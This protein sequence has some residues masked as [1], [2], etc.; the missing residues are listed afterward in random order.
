V[1][2]E[3]LHHRLADLA[4]KLVHPVEIFVVPESHATKSAAV[5]HLQKLPRTPEPTDIVVVGD[6]AF[7]YSHGVLGDPAPHKAITSRG[8]DPTLVELSAERQDF[9]VW[10]SEHPFAIADVQPKSAYP[11][12]TRRYGGPNNPFY[13]ELPFGDDDD[14]LS[15]IVVSGPVRPSASGGLF[16]VSLRIN[17]RLIDPHIAT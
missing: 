14:D 6:K 13:R 16:K 12:T 8:S 4:V 9:V 17:G 15:R 2:T 7:H 11:D 1:A 10:Y 5:S 3:L